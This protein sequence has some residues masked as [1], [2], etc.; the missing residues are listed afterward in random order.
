MTRGEVGPGSRDHQFLISFP[1]QTTPGTYTLTVG[2]AIR[3][4]YGNQM[5]Q[6]G[7]SINEE[8]SDAFI[9]PIPETSS[10]ATLNKQDATTQGT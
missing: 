4:W 1:G 7:N 10:A 9:S 6:N 3:D 8:A 2:P 5:N